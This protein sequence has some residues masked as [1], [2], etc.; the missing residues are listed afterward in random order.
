MVLTSFVE[1]WFSGSQPCR[2]CQHG[3]RCSVR[4]Q[5]ADMYPWSGP[6]PNLPPPDPGQRS[7]QH[8]SHG[9]V[10][11]DDDE[12][13]GSRRYPA[14]GGPGAGD[15]GGDGPLL[16]RTRF[17]RSSSSL[18]QVPEETGIGSCQD[19]AL[20]PPSTCSIRRARS[21]IPHTVTFHLLLPTQDAHA[22]ASIPIYR[23]RQMR[24]GHFLLREF[25]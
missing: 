7:F 3:H 24:Q 20:M 4:P 12:P 9:T 5:R 10:S 6:D 15:F 19:P 8:G 16:V 21:D 18:E 22:G 1:G 14:V 23:W 17:S 25:Y 11:G 2:K 13:A